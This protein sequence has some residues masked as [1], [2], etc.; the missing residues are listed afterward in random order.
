MAES[1]LRAH[2]RERIVYLNGFIRLKK[3]AWKKMI[4]FPNTPCITAAN[5]TFKHVS[6]TFVELN[7]FFIILY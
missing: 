4:C 3:A 7:S 5:Y 2:K 1:G 6:G